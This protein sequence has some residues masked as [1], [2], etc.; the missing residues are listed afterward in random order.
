MHSYSKD[1]AGVVW[2]KEVSGGSSFLINLGSR[3]VNDANY[4]Y[5]DG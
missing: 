4:I 2:I 3:G 5:E 1:M